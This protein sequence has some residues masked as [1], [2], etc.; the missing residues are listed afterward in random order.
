MIPLILS[1]MLTLEISPSRPGQSFSQPQLAS[2]GK[3]TG[4][5]FGSM[6]SIYYSALDSA[7]VKVA[8]APGLALGNHR[9]PRLAFTSDAIVITATVG[10]ADQQYGPGTLRSW[11]SNDRGATW[12]PGPDLSG[13]GSAGM[14]FHALASDGKQRLWA[15]WI[16]PDNGHPTLFVNHSEDGGR[17]WAKQRVLSPSVCECC[18]PTVAISADRV[19]RVMF[20][21]SVNGDRDMYLATL[22]EGETVQIVKLGRGSWKIDACPMDGG[23]MAEFNGR[24]VTLWRREARLFLAPADGAGEEFIAT[25]RNPA[26]TLRQDGIYAIWSS[27]EGIVVMTPGKS[28]RSVSKTGAYPS[29]AATG[30]VVVAWED[31]GKIHVERVP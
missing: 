10:P 11:R 30:P 5:V 23:G 22:K 19:V 15:A 16:G 6:N 14:G 21:N 13:M 17:V 26:V 25:G 24:V 18:H 7:P 8:D 9:G 12:I 20:R 4:V 31:A 3:V 2:D 29:I 28:A 27:P 1:A